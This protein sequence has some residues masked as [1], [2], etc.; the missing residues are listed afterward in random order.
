MALWKE[1]TENE[2]GA[3]PA[4]EQPPSPSP[5]P[6]VPRKEISVQDRHESFF[7]P[8]VNI[9]GKLE[10]AADVRIG[11]KFTGTIEISGNLKIDK[12]AH[13]S[14]TISATTVTIEGEVEGNV[15]ASAQVKLMESGQVIGDIKAATLTVAAGSRMRGK[16]DSGWTG[17]ETARLT[18]IKTHEKAK[19][20]SAA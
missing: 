15:S 6:V 14:A 13:V 8:G 11:G 18:N 2:Q 1:T 12:G 4:Q 10:G 20:G 7:G 19:T 3:A 5:S 17:S 9:E 16:V